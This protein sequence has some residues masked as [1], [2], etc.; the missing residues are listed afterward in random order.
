M[1]DELVWKI[2]M[3]DNP[4]RRAIMNTYCVRAESL[5]EAVEKAID[6][7]AKFVEELSE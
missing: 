7:E 3:S 6:L 2:K 4:T 5:V 1:D